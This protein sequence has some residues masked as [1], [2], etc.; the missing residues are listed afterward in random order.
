MKKKDAK[1]RFNKLIINGKILKWNKFIKQLQKIQ[2]G[3]PKT[4]EKQ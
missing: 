1:I 3:N 2:M 4:D